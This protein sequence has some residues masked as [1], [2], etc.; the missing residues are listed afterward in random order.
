MKDYII[1]ILSCICVFLAYEYK[2]QLNEKQRAENNFNVLTKDIQYLKTSTGQIYAKTGVY[3]NTY[4][5]LSQELK[6][7]LKQ[8]RIKRNIK[9]ITNN[10][11][12]DSAV[13]IGRLRDSLIYDSIKI[14]T[15]NYSNEFNSFNL[16]LINDSVVANY[17]S[18][19]PLD[20]FIYRKRTWKFW[21]R[22]VFEQIIT[23]KNPNAKIIF[24]KSIKVD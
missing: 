10:V 15:F 8:F 2:H 17:E 21:K 7:E 16:M 22:P 4:R 5:E 11:I 9:Q 1:V 24:S 18:I 23:S 3:E 6:S 19:I 13:Y 20:Q 12:K 14:S